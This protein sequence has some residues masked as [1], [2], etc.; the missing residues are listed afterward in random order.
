M[1]NMNPSP[2][3]APAFIPRTLNELAELLRSDTNTLLEIL[4]SD[5]PDV[6][7]QLRDLFV[8]LI[9][10]DPDHNMSF[11]TRLLILVGNANPENIVNNES[12]IHNRPSID[13]HIAIELF[14][15]YTD[16]L[17]YPLDEIDHRDTY[18]FSFENWIES[19]SYPYRCNNGLFIQHALNWISSVRSAA[20]THIGNQPEIND[21]ESDSDSESVNAFG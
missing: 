16:I 8:S 7:N 4:L 11:A 13:Q 20:Q 2:T 9:W 21:F 10:N 12:G 1:D 15:A 19:H 6:K 3:S 5:E 14:D 17:L 18:G